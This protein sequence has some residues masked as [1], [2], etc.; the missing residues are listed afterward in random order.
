MSRPT[1]TKN[2]TEL[3]V[4]RTAQNRRIGTTVTSLNP[5]SPSFLAY[6]YRYVDA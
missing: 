6:N 2:V 4:I 3:S 5:H 1:R